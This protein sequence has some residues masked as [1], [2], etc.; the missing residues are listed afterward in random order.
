MRPTLKFLDDELVRQIVAEALELLQDPGVRVHNDEALALLAAAGASVEGQAQVAHIPEPVV[1]KALET[2]PSG[3][4][5]HDLDG[6][7]VVRYGG[8]HVQFDPGSAALAILD[9]DTREQ[10]PPVTADFVRFVQLVEMLPQIDAQ[11]TAMICADVPPEIGDLY[12]LYLALNYIRKPIITGA[13]RKDTW[14]TMKEMPSRCRAGRRRSRPGR[15]PSSMCAR[16]RR[17]SGAIS[18]AR[19]SST[20]RGAA[21]RPSWS[22]CRWLAPPRR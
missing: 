7:P 5:L 17:C 10:R 21:S 18:P 16:R 19:T 14:W 3:F 11:S 13:F 15:S 2:A 1:R 8:D 6:K 20:A 9:G 12:R 22:R 4:D